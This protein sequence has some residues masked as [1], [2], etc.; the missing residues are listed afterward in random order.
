M[1]IYKKTMLRTTIGAKSKSLP[2]Y[3]HS[4]EIDPNYDLKLNHQRENE[5]TGSHQ[6][7]VEHVRENDK[8]DDNNVDNEQRNNEE[9]SK[10]IDHL[11]QS[12]ASSTTPIGRPLV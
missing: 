7:I 3:L 4:Q 5:A 6:E 9:L 12:E 8:F 11:L 1:E 2:A 10:L